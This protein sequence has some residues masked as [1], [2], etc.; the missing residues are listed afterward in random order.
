MTSILLKNCAVI[1]LAGPI[2]DS[3]F[4]LIEG[5]R[6]AAVGP[7]S[8]A[9]A[10][11]DTVIDAPQMAA[12]PGLVNAHT[13]LSQSFVRGLADEKP[14]AAWL[15][16]VIW[17]VQAAMT[18]E[19]VYLA[20]LL[21][22]VENLTCGVTALTEHHKITTSPA[23]TDAVLQAASEIGLGFTLAYGWVDLGSGAQPT[24][25]ILAELDRLHAEYHGDG[26]QIAV[27][28]MAPWR[29]SD[30]L[31]RE[32]FARAEVWDAPFHLHTAETRAEV[33]LMLARNG[34]R[35][36]EWLNELSVL[37]PRT[38][39]VHS[40]W[41]SEHE[42]MLIERSGARVVHCATSNMILGSGVAPIPAL[43]A[44]GIPISLGADGSGSNNN[45]DMVEL[46]KVTALLAKVGTLDANALNPADVLRMATAGTLEAGA[47]ADVI[48]IDLNTPRSQP[49]HNAASAVVYTASGADV[50]TV[51]VGG[52]VLL[53]NK[54]VIGVDVAALLE[55]CRVAAKDL[56]RRAGVV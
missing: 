8:Q 45:Q 52:R 7:L 21:G 49:V 16:E 36:V 5:D 26:L 24:D 1:T 10:G 14:L 11:A 33:D 34:L 13:H 4:V 35:H 40:V 25:T 41:I 27:G 15:R 43:R 39:L 42:Q 17:P 51:I 20:T 47:R 53:R 50:D 23:H 32:T 22:L 6:I 46:L 55:R 9:P 31:M 29:C 56:M 2:H 28:P 54:Q 30:A 38:Q 19:D 44:R 3:G 12:L 48:L 37:A 18:P